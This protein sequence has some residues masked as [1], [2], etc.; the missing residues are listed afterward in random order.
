MSKIKFDNE[1]FDELEEDEEMS[2]NTHSMKFLVK[3]ERPHCRTPIPPEQR[4][5]DRK[6][7]MR[8]IRLD[9]HKRK[10]DTTD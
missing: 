4:H 10:W 6:K 3:I 7:D 2:H 1:L 9:K 5:P 8:K